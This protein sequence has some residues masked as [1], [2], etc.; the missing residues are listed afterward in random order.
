MNKNTSKT[1]LNNL[2]LEELFDDE[3]LKKRL[4]FQENFNDISY[5]CLGSP[6]ISFLSKKDSNFG[7]EL[8]LICPKI[9]ANDFICK[10]AI[11]YVDELTNKSMTIIAENYSLINNTNFIYFSTTDEPDFSDFLKRNLPS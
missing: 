3:S 5:F 7:E 11:I 1:E 10:F 2:S 9:L 8:K 4:F 6:R